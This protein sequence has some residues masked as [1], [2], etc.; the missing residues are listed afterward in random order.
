MQEHINF[1]P[2]PGAL[3]RN[4]LKAVKACGIVLAAINCFYCVAFRERGI[5]MEISFSRKHIC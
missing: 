3:V 1:W 5:S 2:P 4:K